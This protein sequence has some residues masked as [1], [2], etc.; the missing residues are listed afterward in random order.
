MRGFSLQIKCI[1]I[2]LTVSRKLKAA[3]SSTTVPEKWNSRIFSSGL[4]CQTHTSRCSSLT[5]CGEQG[6]LYWDD[7]WAVA[8]AHLKQLL[9][10][11]VPRVRSSPR[12]A[13][14]RGGGI[15]WM[16]G[17]VSDAQRSD[18]DALHWETPA[19]EEFGVS[20]WNALTTTKWQIPSFFSPKKW[21]W[22]FH[23]AVVVLSALNERSLSSMCNCIMSLFM[24][25]TILHPQLRMQV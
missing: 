5:G 11:T 22:M 24:Q 20:Q 19:S 7:W 23:F 18:I 1:V 25:C 17:K 21:L 13:W 2:W 8:A 14:K 9:F 12:T 16:L 10:S 6:N 3:L 15:S 4:D